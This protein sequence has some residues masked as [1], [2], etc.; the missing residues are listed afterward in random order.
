MMVPTVM[1]AIDLERRVRRIL[2][3]EGTKSP[4]RYAY[5]GDMPGEDRRQIIDAIRAGRQ[6]VLIAAPE[7]IA[8]SLRNPLG[9]AA[10]AGFLTHFVIDEAHLVEQW[11]NDFRPSFQTIASQRHDW[12]RKAPA[13]RAPRTI[14]MSATLTA[15]QVQTLEA[16]FGA[17]GPVE[18][19]WASQLRTEPSYYIESF[20]DEASRAAAVTGAATLLPR[21]L[22]LYVSK[23]EDARELVSSLQAAGLKRVAEVTGM[24]RDDER[25]AALEGWSATS[26]SGLVPSR[27]DVLVGT[28]ALGLGVDL[29]DV[30][31]VIHACIP[32]TVDRYYQEV[33]RGGRDGSPCLSYLATAPSDLPVAEDLNAQ[34]II[35]TERAWERWRAMFQSH[36]PG[37]GAIYQV[38]LDARPADLSEG[39]GRNRM[40]NVRVLNLMARAGLIRLH[41]PEPPVRDDDPEEAW[42]ARQAAFYSSVATRS[43]ISLLDGQ[44][45][46]PSHFRAVL[47]AARN[48]ILGGQRNALVQLRAALRGG[49]CISDV[50]A[51]YY[52]IQ[53]PDGPLLTSPWCRGCPHCRRTGPPDGFCR[54]GWQPHPLLPAWPHEEPDPLARFRG[55][56]QGCLSIWWETEQERRDLVPELLA[57]MCRAGM[58]VIG[59]PGINS[60]AADEIQKEARPHP[61]ILDSDENL[62]LTYPGPVIW[63]LGPDA[64]MSS[65]VVGR[66]ETP[67]VTYLV[68]PRH[69]AH[70]GK[71]N[72]LFAEIHRPSISVGTAGR[73]L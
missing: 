66:I 28:S 2:E 29:P 26:A 65:Q 5:A 45:N 38:D 54:V 51:P 9:E 35:T 44:T 64:I 24:S 12:I 47:G 39:Y 50:L 27:F 3:R 36:R 55:P 17:P 10:E 21:P 63:L 67:D 53:G 33:G 60:V 43:D 32:E 6:R 30:K 25:R 58:P 46:D 61:V 72:A 34:A 11:G 15:L 20:P 42:Q 48:R 19:V 59:G 70:P 16:L 23:R 71:P 31:T 37:P 62:L 14:A 40:W 68:H 52:M 4:A 73:E 13:G 7:A 8:M 56:D 1:L 57:R 18:V 49:K 22:A 41:V 69:L